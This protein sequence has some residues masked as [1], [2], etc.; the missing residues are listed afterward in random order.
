[1]FDM[2]ALYAA[3]GKKDRAHGDL[4]GNSYAH[5]E[6]LRKR[7]DPKCKKCD[8]AGYTM[9]GAQDPEFVC[10]CVREPATTS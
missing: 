6:R 9:G 7:A 5:Y 2:P 3:N 4:R 10:K 1:M 8:G